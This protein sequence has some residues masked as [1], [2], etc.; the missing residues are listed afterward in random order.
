MH[1]AAPGRK[2]A[3]KDPLL[4]CREWDETHS[5]MEVRKEMR[6]S[7]LTAPGDIV[8]VMEALRSCIVD[9][10]NHARDFISYERAS[11]CSLGMHFAQDMSADSKDRSLKPNQIQI[12][13]PASPAHMS[14]QLKTGDEIVAVDGIPTTAHNLAKLLRGTDVIGS[15][16]A[17]TAKRGSHVFDVEL[18]R[19]AASFLRNTDHFMN[20][21]EILEQQIKQRASHD[22]MKPSLQALIAHAIDTE[23]TRCSAEAAL[24]DRL[25]RLQSKMVGLIN[26]M[27]GMLRPGEVGPGQEHLRLQVN[28]HNIH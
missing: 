25:F 1:A 8:A 9:R 10:S 27:E 11:M 5:W 18:A 3:N 12:L 28:L 20:L 4:V 15:K 22:A 7:L 24:A 13:V 19:T 23:R 16:C 17:V 21:A 2:S 26:D 14:G 6:G